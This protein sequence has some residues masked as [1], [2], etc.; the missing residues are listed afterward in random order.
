MEEPNKYLLQRSASF[1]Q[2][3]RANWCAWL[4]YYNAY[5]I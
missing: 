4:N 3:F 1:S 5:W 2:F